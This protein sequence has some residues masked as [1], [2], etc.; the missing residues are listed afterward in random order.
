MAIYGYTQNYKLIK[1]KYD[2]DTWHDY[3]YNNLDTI[4]AVLSS[5]FASGNWKGFWANNTAYAVGDVVIDKGESQMYQVL[6][7]HTTD[8][9]STF[10]QYRTANPTYYQE[11]NANKLAKDWANKTSGPITDLYVTDYSSKAYAIGGVGTETNNSKYYS[12]QASASE[13]VATT[14]ANEASAS[15]SAAAT[16]ESNAKTSELNAKQSEVNAKSSETVAKAAQD[17]PNVVA[18]GTDIRTTDSAIK[19]VAA[20]MNDVSA[21]AMIDNEVVTVSS[22]INQVVTVAG[23]KDQVVTT[24]EHATAIQQIGDNINTV[25]NAP[26]DAERSRIFAYGTDAE[27]QTLGGVHSAEGWAKQ[28]KASAQIRDATESTFGVVSLAT[29]A[30][31]LAG[32]D[33]TKAMTPL[34]SAQAITANVGRGLQLGFN[35]TLAGSVLTFE[36]DQSAYEMKQG[37]DYEIDLLF[38]AAG[39]LP[40]STQMVIKNGVDTVQIVNVKHAD[41]ST[42][43]TYGDM[44]QMCRYDANIGLRWIFNARYAITDTGVKV[45]VMPSAVIADD[46]Y[47]TTDT[48]QI[49]SAGKVM[50]NVATATSTDSHTGMSLTLKNTEA[51]ITS[52][53][54]G[55]FN[56][57]GV[58]F[59]DKNNEETGFL[60][61]TPNGTGGT[62]SRLGASAK[63]D[64]QYVDGFIQVDVDSAGKAHCYIPEVDEA[65]NNGV[66]AATVNYVK[67]VSSGLELMDV[68]FAPLGIDETKNKRRYLNGQVIIQSQFPA[69]TAAIKA[70]MTTMANA[71]TTEVNWQAEKTQ[72]K[73]GQCGKFVVDDAAGTI[74]LP[75]VVNAQGLVDL[76]LIGGTKSES[77]PQHTH[78]LSLF[79][80]AGGVWGTIGACWGGDD[81][82]R[83]P[84]DATTTKASHSTYQDNAPVQQEAIQYPYCIVV[85]TGVDETERP[86]NN[87]QVNNVYSYGMSQYY[88]GT[89]NNNSWLKSAGQWNDGTVY[90]GMYNWLVEQMNTG[91]SSFVASTATYTDYDFVINTT[92]QTF[93]LPLLNGNEVIPD[94]ENSQNIASSLPFTSSRNGCIYGDGDGL[95]SQYLLNGVKVG[96]ARGT[97]AWRSNGTVSVFVKRGDVFNSTAD[98]TSGDNFSLSFVPAVGNGNLYYYVGDT[99]QNAQLIN[100]ARIEE[101]LLNTTNKVQAAEASMPSG[102]Y[103]DL[104]LGA[105]SQTYTAPANG[106]F[107]LHKGANNVNQY[108]YMYTIG[109][110]IGT[111]FNVS[112]GTDIPSYFLPVK[113]GDTVQIDYTLGGATMQFRFVYA[114][115]DQ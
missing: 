104:T 84:Y 69:F 30:E 38:P 27:V 81:A 1:P 47:V 87:Y 57:Q 4:D 24:A 78:N 52:T 74:R 101:T 59:V 99:L 12:Q 45:L 72:S 35:G 114:Q 32:T 2:T 96:V 54:M 25:M 63:V 9:G 89:M 20:D 79:Q 13:A 107:V 91:V 76:A 112:S 29:E 108:V 97:S 37:Y 39:T 75:C 82:R 23:I 3:E 64:G 8:V 90:T 105:S 85:N 16:S 62:M 106:W 40:D 26:Q 65:D 50:T 67:K 66:Q 18:V 111:C 98:F 5:I 41:A 109:I 80:A 110:D 86:I 77:L 92:D 28:A 42:P 46:R 100:V 17:D 88:K 102:K 113:A 51:D 21:V 14:K 70:R 6:V 10:Y 31:A 11:W 7:T 103:I 71:F 61:N 36:P 22:A 55:Q 83:G 19:K 44:K 60:Y 53:T 33:D 115:G 43:I 73:L 34:K 58:R 95:D 49:I 56:Y 48:V 93:R 94:W 15:A 68:V